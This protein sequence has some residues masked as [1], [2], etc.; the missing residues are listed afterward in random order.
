MPRWIWGAAAVAILVSTVATVAMYARSTLHF[1]QW[2]CFEES[3][4]KADDR[5]AIVEAANDALALVKRGDVDTLVRDAHPILLTAFDR[6]AAANGLKQAAEM[7][8][9]VALP[10]EPID[11]KLITGDLQRYTPVNCYPTRPNGLRYGAGAAGS[12]PRALVTFRVEAKPV[13]FSFHAEVW[14]HEGRWRLAYFNFTPSAHNGRDSAYYVRAGDDAAAKGERFAAAILYTVAFDLGTISTN[15][16]TN[17]QSAIRAKQ[18]PFLHDTQLNDALTNWIVG[19]KA[20]KVKGYMAFPNPID[21]QWF[22]LGVGFADQAPADPTA[23][24]DWL[25]ATHPILGQHFDA[26]V[27]LSKNGE[28]VLMRF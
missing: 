12:E 9:G 17:E 16:V 18:Q 23:V 20:Y 6:K 13:L 15:V 4:I 3:E 1:T 8:A 28:P 27:F 22:V 5:T 21:R 19:G 25:K 14:K 26:V 2:A 11:V 10:R 24:F 7:L